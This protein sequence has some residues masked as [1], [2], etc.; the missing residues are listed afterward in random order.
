M[1][2]SPT[3]CCCPD[4]DSCRSI[5]TGLNEFGILETNIY[6]TNTK[7]LINKEIPKYSNNYVRQQGLLALIRDFN[8]LSVA[9]KLPVQVFHYSPN[10]RH[11]LFREPKFHHIGTPKNDNG[12][13][14]LLTVHPT[15][16]INDAVKEL[17]YLNQLHDNDKEFTT[18]IIVVPITS[19]ECK[20][21][22][23]DYINNFM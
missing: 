12:P 3:A 20:V 7:N 13:R 14:E 9:D 23:E 15:Y 21:H 8:T 18:T 6:I 10:D 22:N 2:Y 1:P 5:T 16:E 19:Q 4:R 11:T 17:E